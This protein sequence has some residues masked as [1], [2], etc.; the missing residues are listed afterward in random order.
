MKQRYRYFTAHRSLKLAIKD[1]AIL[2][3][4][5]VGPSDVSWQ[6]VAGTLATNLR[7]LANQMEAAWEG[8]VEDGPIVFPSVN[9]IIEE[10]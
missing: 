5:E 8:Y 6:D 3:G 1:M 2:S 10:D 4:E 7:V 9:E